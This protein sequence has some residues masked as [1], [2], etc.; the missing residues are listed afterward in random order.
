[1]IRQVINAVLCLV[2]L[3]AC[4]RANGNVVRVVDPPPG[5]HTYYGDHVLLSGRLSGD[6]HIIVYGTFVYPG[7]ISVEDPIDGTGA[8]G[9]SGGAGNTMSWLDDVTS[10]EPGGAGGDGYNLTLEVRP[11]SVFGSSGPGVISIINTI[12]LSGGNGGAGGNGSN[13]AC[14]NPN[15]NSPTSCIIAQTQSGA[16]GGDGGRSGSLR[17]LSQ[18]G[19]GVLITSASLGEIRLNGGNGGRGGSGGSISDSTS[20][21]IA[22]GSAMAGVGG[23][24]GNGG[25]GGTLEVLGPNAEGLDSYFEELAA[26]NV[27][28]AVIA[29]KGGDGGDGGRG[30]NGGTPPGEGGSGGHAGFGGD[31]NWEGKLIH[32]HH[33]SLVCNPGSPG[34][35]GTGGSGRGEECSGCGCAQGQRCSSGAGAYGGITGDAASGGDVLVSVRYRILWTDSVV[36]TSGLGHAGNALTAA[37]D[38]GDS[39]S[40][41]NGC[42]TSEVCS[43]PYS[44]STGGLGRGGGDAGSIT[45]R[46]TDLPPWDIGCNFD[47]TSFF[48]RGGTGTSGGKGGDVTYGGGGSGAVLCGPLPDGGLGGTGG[49]GGSA[50]DIF[51]DLQNAS[52]I[53][54]TN[55]VLD[56]SGGNGG[57]GGNGGR[58]SGVGGPGGLGGGAATAYV[59]GFIFDVSG[60]T[61]INSGGAPGVAGAVGDP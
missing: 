30:G 58:P 15:P 57:N 60:T 6:T 53:I 3:P 48:A 33:L 25:D 2:V 13:G 17:L 35:G 7:G 14:Y 4:A 50:A 8:A 23:R 49:F 51:L 56:C 46:V 11:S 42:A 32:V 54:L 40:A 22:L 47:R 37:G 36:D 59:S 18:G 41:I 9:I 20:A 43:A 27:G 45:F 39:G 34:N 55:V 12:D 1:M 28:Y 24:G 61:L 21:V 19:G 38:A 29:T 31:T 52:Y 16:A 44:P 26:V 5:V 10:P